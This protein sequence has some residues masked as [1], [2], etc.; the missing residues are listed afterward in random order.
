MHG[1]VFE[2]LCEGCG[3]RYNRAF[4]TLDDTAGQYFEDMEDYGRSSI[5]LPPHAKKYKTKL[6]L[7]INSS[8]TRK[9]GYLCLEILT[10][11]GEFGPLGF[12]TLL[13]PTSIQ[14]L[15]QNV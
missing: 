11:R 10:G 3:V 12:P 1:N 15:H 7:Q 6:V 14:L 9:L 2:E 13:H 8:F 4:Y 5:K